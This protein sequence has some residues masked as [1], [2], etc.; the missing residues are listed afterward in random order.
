MKNRKPRQIPSKI[1]GV[2]EATLFDKR[3]DKRTI[4]FFADGIKASW[5][6]K[7]SP[8]VFYDECAKRGELGTLQ[9]I[10]NQ[11]DA[12]ESTRFKLLNAYK[13]ALAESD[14]YIGSLVDAVDLSKP[15]RSFSSDRTFLCWAFWG[16]MGPDTLASIIRE[17][18][19]RPPTLAHVHEFFVWLYPECKANWPESDVSRDKVHRT[20]IDRMG[21]PLGQDRIGR[22][23]KVK[24]SR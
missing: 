6:E 2:R 21:L 23:A 13:A 19:L 15:P 10:L 12:H 11:G 8:G 22:P 1:F 3:D 20:T 5:H 24:T 16:L 4:G 7:K 18:G 14:A 9:K 17:H